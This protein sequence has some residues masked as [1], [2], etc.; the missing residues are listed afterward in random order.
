MASDGSAPDAYYRF[1]GDSHYGKTLDTIAGILNSAGMIF[2]LKEEMERHGRWTPARAR[3][4]ARSFFHVV[5]LK[6]VDREEF[7][8][9]RILLSEARERDLIS[10]TQHGA[11]RC[12]ATGRHMT[13]G[14][15]RATFYWNRLARRSV[16]R[17]WFKETPWTYGNQVTPAGCN[18]P[19]VSARV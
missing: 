11:L 8:H 13:R 16:V 17:R 10:A 6:L 7:D 2:W 19:A 1:H 3:S 4:L 18:F 9:A 5:I 12:Y 14:K 15:V